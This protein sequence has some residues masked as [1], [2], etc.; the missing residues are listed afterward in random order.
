MDARRQI[1]TILKDSGAILKRQN[2]N[3]IYQLPGDKGN[4]VMP[5]TDVKSPRTWR[6]LYSELKHSLGIVAPKKPEA[7]KKEKRKRPAPAVARQQ[8]QTATAAQSGDS[9]RGSRTMQ[10]ALLVAGLQ[11]TSYSDTLSSFKPREYG[12]F[13]DRPSSSSNLDSE[14]LE[15]AMAK[16]D[17]QGAIIPGN[18][19][20]I[21]RKGYRS[22]APERG[23][24]H[25]Y[26]REEI[27]EI[28]RIRKNYGELALS[29][30]LNEKHVR[31][32]YGD[33]PQIIHSQ[34]KLQ[35]KTTMPANTNGN[36]PIS[37]LDSWIADAKARMRR[38]HEFIK[39]ADDARGRIGEFEEAIT[40]AELFKETFSKKNSLLTTTLSQL[41]DSFVPMPGNAAAKPTR[42][43][44]SSGNGTYVE[45]SRGNRIA[46]TIL[47][48]MERYNEPISVAT[49]EAETTIPRGKISAALSYEKI[50]GKR[51][52]TS[53][54]ENRDMKWILTSRLAENVEK[55]RHER[56]EAA[57]AG[58]AA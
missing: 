16:D 34:I 46:D 30:Y 33:K 31:E 38:V 29:D 1:E 7:V 9:S 11:S 49:L 52:V 20:I 56:A 53:I 50:K 10:Q 42:T 44:R 19:V 2:K 37:Q 18:R 47:A 21:R 28:N 48:V 45:G 23:A 24:V 6:N 13:S 55:E 36:N 54:G 51:R 4:F 41:I 43:Y 25:S 40:A 27:D 5:R 3:M 26:T 57:V 35:E 14:T 22:R 12:H 17:G 58:S 8:F 15:R 39:A 32:Q